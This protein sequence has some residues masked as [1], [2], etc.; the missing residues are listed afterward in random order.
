MQ[1]SIPILL[2]IAPAVASACY[3]NDEAPYPKT[4]LGQSTAAQAQEGGSHRLVTL[5]GSIAPLTDHFNANKDK[6]RFLTI[7]SPT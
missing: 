1:K 6:V 5:A 3:A 4:T 2:L 7:L